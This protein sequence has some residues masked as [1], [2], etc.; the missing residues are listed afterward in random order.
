MYQ[1]DAKAPQINTANQNVLNILNTWKEAN[2]DADIDVSNYASAF[3]GKEADKS[4]YT[5]NVGVD[6]SGAQDKFTLELYDGGSQVQT[7]PISGREAKQIRPDLTIAPRVSRIN[8]I[9]Q[10]S[11]QGNTSNSVTSNLNASTAYTGAYIKQNYFINQ[12][13]RTDI[14][15][16]D[17]KTNKMGEVNLYLYKKDADDNVVAIPIKRSNSVYPEPFTSHDDAM[18]FLQTSVTTSGQI[19]NFIKNTK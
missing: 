15:G 19:D 2:K 6:R 3:S 7:I 14:L 18:N 10:Q 16:A 4:K 8:Q 5:V 17:T 9:V 1:P 11:P 12:F 13:N